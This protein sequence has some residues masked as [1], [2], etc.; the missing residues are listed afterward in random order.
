MIEEDILTIIK[1]LDKII[2]SERVEVKNAFRELLI[3]VTLCEDS[4]KGPLEK[5]INQVNVMQIEIDMVKKTSNR[6]NEFDTPLSHNYNHNSRPTLQY[7]TVPNTVPKTDSQTWIT[8]P[9]IISKIQS[10]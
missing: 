2:M 1:S 8:P 4:V 7:G 10:E 9:H 5:L 3:M 6:I